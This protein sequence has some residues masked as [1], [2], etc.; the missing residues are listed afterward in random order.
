MSRPKDMWAFDGKV[1]QARGPEG[2]K[3]QSWE[4]AWLWPGLGEGLTE[5]GRAVGEGPAEAM[6]SEGHG[7]VGQTGACSGKAVVAAEGVDGGGRGVGAR[8]AGTW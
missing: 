5:A 2:T 4:G 3:S 7:Q 6:N 1:T 8:E